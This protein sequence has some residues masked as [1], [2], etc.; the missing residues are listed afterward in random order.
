M[1]REQAQQL[2]VAF[3]ALAPYCPPILFDRAALSPALN[4]ILQVANGQI[5]LSSRPTALPMK[6]E[7]EK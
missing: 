2:I 5:E 7:E 6:G 3:N 4:V 1:N